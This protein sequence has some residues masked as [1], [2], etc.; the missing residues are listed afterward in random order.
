[1]GKSLIVPLALPYQMVALATTLLLFLAT[2]ALA[3]LPAS[4]RG[5]SPCVY[6]LPFFRSS[7]VASAAA[8]EL[9][10]LPP[11]DLRRIAMLLRKYVILL[12]AV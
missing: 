8:A 2:S 3:K 11:I 12:T 10:A 7:S 5:S 4:L 6:Y 1:M 9:A